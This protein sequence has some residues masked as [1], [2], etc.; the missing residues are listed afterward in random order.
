[1]PSPLTHDDPHGFGPYRLIA[2]LGSGGMGT[3][4]LARSPGGRTVAVKTMHARIATEAAFRTRF[5][6][7][8]DAARVIGGRHGA[9]VVEADPLA[10][11]PWIATEYVLGPPL[12]EAVELAG[13]LPEASVRA[14]GAALCGALGQLHGSDVVHRD[15]KPSNIMVTAHGPKVIDFGIAR[16]LG[17]DRLTHTGAAVGTPAFMSPEQAT[18][19]EHTPAGD[20]FALAGVLVFAATGHGPFGDGRPADLLYRVTY[21]EPDLTGTPA[22]LAPIL[23]GCLAKDPA[24]RPTTAELSARLHDGGGEFADL[25]PDAVLAEI[26]RRA[27]EV[28]QV[29]PQRLPAPADQPETVPMADVPA[30]GGLSR[31]GLLMAGAGSVLGVAGAGAG[32][33]AVLGQDAP[34]PGPGTGP[35][36]TKPKPGPSVGALKKKKLDSVWQKQTGG[37]D[38]D[39]NPEVPMVAGD[40]VVLVAGAEAR[41]VD[42]KSGESA[43]TF[44]LFADDSWQ[45]ASDGERVYQILRVENGQD[46]MTKT[47]SWFLAPVDLRTGKAGTRIAPVS[48]SRHNGIISRLLA[49]ADAT[50]YLAI[51]HGKVKSHERLS[52]WSVTAVDLASGRRKWTDPV[53]FHP[54]KSDDNHFL[55]AKASG[56]RLVLLQQMNDGKVRIVAR[57]TRTGK[58]AWDKPWDGAD[59]RYVR[60]PLAVDGRHLYL[61]YGPLRALRLSDGGQAWDTSSVRPKKTYGPAVLKGGAVYAVEKGLGL[62]S[63][64]AG[65]G[66]PRWAEKSAEG[67]RADHVVRPVIGSEYAYTYSDTDKV[68]RAVGLASRTTEQLYTTSGTRFVAHEKSRM[69]IASGPHFLAGFPLR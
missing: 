62:V 58:V 10:E 68:L 18:G 44:S 29:V 28:W 37:P 15:L 31:R 39:Q 61:G 64:G 33:W 57:D 42:P 17:D 36:Y 30:A 40:Q 7:E 1:M 48:D 12:D 9:Q 59:S 26:G 52:R 54:A 56:N 49:V 60:D 27:S 43:W 55:S 38:D 51:S 6:L 20:V 66:K 65:G 47:V 32:V 14:L 35:G 69:V 41:G 50:A 11:T 63:Y 23:A 16:A 46:L 5:R 2:R 19:G 24:Q 4:Y 22:A 21:G 13:P 25:L 45:V 8:A 3:V 34:A 67:P 53:P